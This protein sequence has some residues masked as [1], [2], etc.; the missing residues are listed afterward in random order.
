MV[1]AHKTSRRRKPYGLQVL[2][3]EAQ[4]TGSFDHGK[5]S[6]SK[7]IGFSGEGSLIK[8]LG[9]CYYWAWAQAS[10][11]SLIPMHPHRGF[12]I[13]SLVL[14]GQVEHQDSMGQVVSLQAGDLQVMQTGHGVEHQERF[15]ETAQ[16]IQIWFDPD[17]REEIKRPPRYLFV[18]AGAQPQKAEKPGWT[19][20]FLIGG[21]SPI[22][23]EAPVTVELW[24][25]A[26][27]TRL[28]W[29]EPERIL[30]AQVLAGRGQ[31]GMETAPEN[32]LGFGPG[33]YILA[34]L[35]TAVPVELVVYE[36]VRLLV[37]NLAQN[38]TY[39]LFPKV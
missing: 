35:E 30:A 29:D 12:E 3:P 5:I 36:D 18:E 10:A 8:R 22:A 14:A 32:R 25:L 4:V 9:P 6:E 38:P 16:M 7:M 37:L 31:W 2:G 24:D 23:L 33:D 27:D 20:R 1:A 26:A 15:G 39:R 17:F 28:V 19:R 11:E 21:R 34:D 13:L